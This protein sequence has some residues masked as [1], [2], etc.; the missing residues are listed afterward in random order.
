LVDLQVWTQPVYPLDT[1][2]Y[3]VTQRTYWFTASASLRQAVTLCQNGSSFV[4][5][6]LAL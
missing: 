4:A 5:V 6:F 2:S 3:A 1:W